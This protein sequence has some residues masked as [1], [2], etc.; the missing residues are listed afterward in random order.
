MA[1]APIVLFVYNRPWHTKQTVEALL[2][3]IYAS[4]S[5][6]FIFSDGP[7]NEN[8]TEKVNEVRNYIKSLSGFK[9]INIIESSENKGLADSIIEGVT[10]VVNQ[11]GKIIVLEDDIVTSPGF[12]KYMNDALTLYEMDEKV[13]HI[14]GYVFPVKEILPITFFYNS[15]SCWGWATW[16][17]AWKYFNNDANSL[18]DKI[19]NA[20][21]IHQFNIEG[22]YDFLSQLIENKNGK[23]KTWAVKW[24]ASVF[25][26]NGLSLHPY[27]SLVNNIGNDGNGENCGKTDIYNWEYLAEYIPIKRIKLKESRNARKHISN[28]FRPNKPFIYWIKIF[29]SKIL[30]TKLYSFIKEFFQAT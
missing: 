19:N 6:L 12:L 10:D 21:I 5:E 15:T 1:L 3:N 23:M 9:S 13:M 24:Y 27:P 8:V 22:S 7:K 30:P 2:K 28:F 11:Y 16:A 20:K 4:E 14:S 26:N 17:H 18:L 29:L 25:L